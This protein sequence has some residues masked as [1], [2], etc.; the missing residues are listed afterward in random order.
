LKISMIRHGEGTHTLNEPISF[1][2]KNPVLTDHGIYEIEKIKT[3][4][5]NQATII[6][7]PTMR[8]IQTGKILVGNIH[9]F[10]YLNLF[11][12]RIYPYKKKSV[13][14]C[15]KIMSNKEIQESFS[16]LKV[17]KMVNFKDIQIHP[18]ELSIE[19][20]FRKVDNFFNTLSKNV[21]EVVIITHDGPIATVAELF[22]NS[23]FYRNQ[24]N[25][26]MDSGY[27]FE[28]YYK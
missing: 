3:K 13:L 26:I 11:G 28:F 24:N 19:E 15:D 9:E 10:Y 6:T 27:V 22:T 8:T 4:I 20:Y 14:P 25:D 1:K 5:N 12:P 23:K 2:I 21:K 16:K 7:S 18:N 17:F